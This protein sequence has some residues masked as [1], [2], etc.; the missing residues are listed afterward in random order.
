MMT[1]NAMSKSSGGLKAGEIFNIRLS[2]RT[3]RQTWTSS[4]GNHFRAAL[5][6]NRELLLFIALPRAQHSIYVDFSFCE[7]FMLGNASFV[8]VKMLESKFGSGRDDW[9]GNGNFRSILHFY[10][11]SDRV[12]RRRIGSAC[13]KPTKIHRQ[14]SVGWESVFHSHFP[15]MEMRRESFRFPNRSRVLLSRQAWKRW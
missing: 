8:G 12:S 1:A 11:F 14:S 5:M 9:T 15:V 10:C 13:Q 2:S 4:I 6:S 3:L 7:D